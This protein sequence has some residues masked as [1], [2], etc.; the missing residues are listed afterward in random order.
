[1]RWR[2]KEYATVTYHD[3][4]NHFNPTIIS[5]TITIFHP[6]LPT[7]NRIH[8]ES[9][10]ILILESPLRHLALGWQICGGAS[11][12]ASDSKE[13]SVCPDSNICWPYLDAWRT[14]SQVTCI[15]EIARKTLQDQAPKND[16]IKKTPANLTWW[17]QIWACNFMW[18]SPVSTWCCEEQA[19]QTQNKFQHG[20]S[21]PQKAMNIGEIACCIA[22]DQRWWKEKE[23]S[24]RVNTSTMKPAIIS[25]RI[26]WK[27]S[28]SPEI[29]SS[30]F[31]RPPQARHPR[32]CV[33]LVSCDASGFLWKPV[34]QN[35]SHEV[36]QLH[37]APA[38]HGI[39]NLDVNPD[40]G[41]MRSM[42]SF[43]LLRGNLPRS[44]CNFMP[45]F[46]QS[47]RNSY[48]IPSL[49]SVSECLALFHDTWLIPRDPL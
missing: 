25:H 1:M 32:V 22:R 46:Q 29:A 23:S 21:R 4:F 26:G 20:V 16:P 41:A 36:V 15:R 28:E 31:A 10:W 35:S 7:A 6:S 34:I 8:H 5:R 44:T 42:P 19:F 37:S 3:T 43:Q 39:P 17:V 12:W 48:P 2:A 13:A 49:T 38:S 18:N 30:C 47:T 33:Q 40:V 45:D 24:M 11:L 14:K 9:S 27:F